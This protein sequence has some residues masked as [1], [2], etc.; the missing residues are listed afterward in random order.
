[1]WRRWK[2]INSVHKAELQCL[3]DNKLTTQM[4]SDHNPHVSIFRCDRNTHHPLQGEHLLTTG[5]NDLIRFGHSV[6]RWSAADNDDAI[7]CSY[8]NNDERSLRMETDS[9]SLLIPALSK[10][11]TVASSVYIHTHL[12]RKKKIIF[13]QCK[14]RSR[15]LNHAGVKR[16][17]FHRRTH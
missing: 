13:H 2:E 3:Y 8:T 5:E 7:R 12:K 11:S 1:M 14:K 15:Q 4:D 9:V 10:M 17:S 16:H 6:S